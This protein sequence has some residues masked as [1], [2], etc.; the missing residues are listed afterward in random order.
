MHGTERKCGA[1][2]DYNGLW[3]SNYSPILIEKIIFKRYEVVVLLR[4][5]V[6]LMSSLAEST[7]LFGPYPFAT[8]AC[9]RRPNSRKGSTNCKESE[10]FSF[11][12]KDRSFKIPSSIERE[13][14]D[15]DRSH[16]ATLLKAD[17][18]ATLVT[19][20]LTNPKPQ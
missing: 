15:S 9:E 1:T 12:A 14:T 3:R 17:F 18:V 4:C 13:C 7:E 20:Y 16:T 5:I 10:S 6:D 19:I 8:L 11:Y 2:E